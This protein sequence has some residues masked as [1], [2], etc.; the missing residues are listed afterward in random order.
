MGLSELGGVAILPRSLHYATRHT[1][2]VCRKKPGHSGRDDRDKRWRSWLVGF[3]SSTWVG[4]RYCH[5]PSTTRPG[6]QKP[7][8]GKSRVASVGMTELFRAALRHG[9]SRLPCYVQCKQAELKRCP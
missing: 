8:A 7:C 2:T 6:T 4:L 3:V 5:G 9:R 1:K